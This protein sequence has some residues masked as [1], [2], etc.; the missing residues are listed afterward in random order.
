MRVHR[1]GLAL[2]LPSG[3]LDITH[4]LPEGSPPTFGKEDGVGVI[5]FSVAR[6][7]SGIQPTIDVHALREM[8]DDFGGKAGLGVPGQTKDGH[9]Q[10]GNRFVTG[11]FVLLQERISA[12]YLTN[13]SDVALVTY[14][15]R[16][17]NDPKVPGE[18]VDASAVVATIEF[19]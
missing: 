4:D 18:L 11:E 12:W 10:R 1:S 15:T 17:P 14:V 6:Y 9:D 16:E 8:L 5:Q 13:G 3:W 2:T 7:T 19:E